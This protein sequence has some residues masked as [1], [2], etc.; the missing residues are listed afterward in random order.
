MGKRS[1]PYFITDKIIFL[2]TF[3]NLIEEGGVI[4]DVFFRSGVFCH[5]FAALCRI[6]L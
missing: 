1:F 3:Q 6:N 2:P 4:F 5:R